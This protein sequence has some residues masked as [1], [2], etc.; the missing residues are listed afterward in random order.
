MIEGKGL[1]EWVEV[2]KHAVDGFVIAGK[3]KATI[4]KLL[5]KVERGSFSFLLPTGKNS[6]VLV[7]TILPP[8]IPTIS[9]YSS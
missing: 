9:T 5:Q 2:Y 7:A 1:W 6:F 8:K 3:F 4:S